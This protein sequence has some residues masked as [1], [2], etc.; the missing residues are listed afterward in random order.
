MAA[1]E[2]FKELVVREIKAEIERR[3]GPP[4]SA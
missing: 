2:K 3:V 4:S 1:A